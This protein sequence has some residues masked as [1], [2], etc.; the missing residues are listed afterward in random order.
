MQINPPIDIYKTVRQVNG[1]YSLIERYTMA[2]AAE[3]V[4][5]VKLLSKYIQLPITKVG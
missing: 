4:R 5:Q 2:A 3:I 1:A